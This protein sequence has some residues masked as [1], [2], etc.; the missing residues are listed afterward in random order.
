MH[1]AIANSIWRVAISGSMG[2]SLGNQPSKISYPVISLGCCFLR[3]SN[4]PLGNDGHHG[5]FNSYAMSLVTDSGNQVPLNKQ[6]LLTVYSHLKALVGVD[7]DGEAMAPLTKM[8]ESS[9][10]TQSLGLSRDR[11]NA[12]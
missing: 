7:A 2:Y 1:R 5:G 12:T 4:S 10:H 9:R 6:S 11:C 3:A 8:P